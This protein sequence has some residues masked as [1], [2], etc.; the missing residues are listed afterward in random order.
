MSP[1]LERGFA[2]VP[3]CCL[4]GWRFFGESQEYVRCARKLGTGGDCRKRLDSLYSQGVEFEAK[5]FEIG[6]AVAFWLKVNNIKYRLFRLRNK[7][8]L[9]VSEVSKSV[10]KHQAVLDVPEGEAS[11]RGSANLWSAS[12]HAGCF[13]DVF[14]DCTGMCECRESTHIG[15]RG[16]SICSEE[17]VGS[18]FSPGRCQRVQST[19][20]LE[21][22][23]ITSP[24][25]ELMPNMRRIDI[26]SKQQAGLEQGLFRHD[27]DSF[28][29]FHCDKLPYLASHREE[30][31]FSVRP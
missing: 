5:R 23:S 31:G 14:R 30:M 9:A 12:G 4:V 11:K 6:S 16:K 13:R 22:A 2:G 1:A 28:I 8:P 10:A 21:N 19:P 17:G 18:V 15:P 26:A 25:C 24:T 3:S 29:E 20:Q 27:T 7:G